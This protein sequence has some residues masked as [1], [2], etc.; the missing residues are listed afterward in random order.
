[1]DNLV[2]R[3]SLCRGWVVYVLAVEL[4]RIVDP[5][6]V[7]RPARLPCPACLCHS[8]CSRRGG[9]NDVVRRAWPRLQVAAKFRK[10]ERVLRV[11]LPTAV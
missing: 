4:P 1:M 3:E 11:R 5:E 8:A 2:R 9:G 6:Q 7:R 10:K